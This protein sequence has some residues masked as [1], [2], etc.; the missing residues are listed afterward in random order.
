MARHFAAYFTLKKAWRSCDVVEL[1]VYSTERAAMHT[2]QQNATRHPDR[3]PHEPRSLVWTRVPWGGL[4]AKTTF[5]R[6]DIR[7]VADE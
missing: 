2:G 4:V 1:G 6:Y 3:A 5:G 7:E